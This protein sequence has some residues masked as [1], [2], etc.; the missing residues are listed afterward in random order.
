MGTGVL[1]WKGMLSLPLLVMLISFSQDG[2]ANSYCFTWTHMSVLT[3][4]KNPSDL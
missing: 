4:A 1:T 2:R 3:V